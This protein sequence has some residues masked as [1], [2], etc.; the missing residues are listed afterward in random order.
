MTFRKRRVAENRPLE[1]EEKKKKEEE[2]RRERCSSAG[3]ALE[4]RVRERERVCVGERVSDF[5]ISSFP[6]VKSM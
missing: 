6:Q 5:V 1:K 3:K 4:R 2:R